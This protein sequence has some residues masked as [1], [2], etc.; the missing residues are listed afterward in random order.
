MDI[1][2]N[3]L[4][5]QKFQYTNKIWNKLE[6]NKAWSVGLLSKL[7][8]QRNFRSKEEWKEYYFESGNKRLEIVN[9]RDYIVQ[10]ILGQRI[11]PTS[12]LNNKYI[13]TNYNYGRT[14]QELEYKGFILY[15]EILKRG[16]PLKITLKECQYAILF[17]VI[18]ETWNGIVQRERNTIETLKGIFSNIADLSFDKTSGERDSLYEVDY[19]VFYKD[20]IICGLQIK[21]DSYIKFNDS[22]LKKLNKIK[23][24]KYKEKYNADVIYIYSSLDGKISNRE[25]VEL[26][27]S[28]IA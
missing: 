20:K 1:F 28:K 13:D 24:D 2:I 19:D 22:N 5:N 15:D 4:D 23:N 8:N 16:N 9:D 26:I 18:C 17:R 11:K 6:L 14:K 21:P 12:K 10:S 27:K 25:I 3:K 7:I